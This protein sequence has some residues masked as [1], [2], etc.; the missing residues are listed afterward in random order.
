MIHKRVRTHQIR[1]QRGKKG[2][3]AYGQTLVSTLL[4]PCRAGKIRSLRKRQTFVYNDLTNSK[5]DFRTHAKI[6][7]HPADAVQLVTC[8]THAGGSSV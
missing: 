7:P 2:L 4:C 1:A 6:K 8:T 3:V 5:F